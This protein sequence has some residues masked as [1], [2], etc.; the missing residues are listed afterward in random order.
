MEK[1]FV[2]FILIGFFNLFSCN[3]EMRLNLVVAFPENKSIENYD[4]SQIRLGSEYTLLE[5]LYSPILEFD[6]QGLLKSNI[7]ED[8]GWLDKTTIYLKVAKNLFDSKGDRLGVK[9]L[10]FT[11]KR[12]YVLNSSLGGHLYSFLKQGDIQ[13][14]S[15]EQPHPSIIKDEVKKRVLLKLKRRNHLIFSILTSIDYGLI[16][17]KSL[18]LE[19]L[20]IADYSRTSGPFYFA[21]ETKKGQILLQKNAYWL[22]ASSHQISSITLV[23]SMDTKSSIDLIGRGRVDLTT[24]DDL[25]SSQSHY[26]ASKK[27]KGLSFFQ[28]KPLRLRLISLTEKGIQKFTLKERAYLFSQIKSTY[29]K[30]YDFGHLVSRA[31]QFFIR[32]AEGALAREDLSSVYLEIEKNKVKQLKDKSFVVAVYPTFVSE[33]KKLFEEL[34]FIKIVPSENFYDFKDKNFDAVIISTDSGLHQ[35]YSLLSYTL[36]SGYFGLYGSEAKKQIVR[37]INLDSNKELVR[38]VEEIHKKALS[39]CFFI[40][41]SR[42]PYTI[43]AREGLSSPIV[44]IYSNTK[45]WNVKVE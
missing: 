38:E 28:T 27:K 3:S 36:G 8:F 40:P 24:T 33:F 35:T 2:K 18:N 45:L 42:S 12:L 16:P 13:L 15:V 31:D 19:K 7:V 10:Y 17:F 34:D 1:S 39:N 25:G 37:L 11:L 9:D 20:S 41:L 43:L 4:T 29:Q 23:P 26:L 44:S 21:G 6:N 5:H 32:G 30:N 14:M 22:S